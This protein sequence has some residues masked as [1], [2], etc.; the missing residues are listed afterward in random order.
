MM[1]EVRQLQLVLLEQV[2][3]VQE[4]QVQHKAAHSMDQMAQQTLVAVVEQAIFALRQL[5]LVE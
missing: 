4:Q 5:C 1:L 3:V 2:V